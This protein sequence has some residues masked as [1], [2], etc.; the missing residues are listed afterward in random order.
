MKPALAMGAALCGL[1][2][3]VA[4]GEKPQVLQSS[5]RDVPAFQGAADPF[6]VPG[7]KA[8]ERVSWEQGLKTRMQNSQNEYTKLPVAK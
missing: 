6:V 8:G 5:K 2:G 7:W 3:L 1:F 4:C